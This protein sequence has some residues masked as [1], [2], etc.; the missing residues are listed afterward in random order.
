[1]TEDGRQ[2]KPGLRSWNDAIE[3][4]L[5]LAKELE[6]QHELLE[7]DEFGVAVLLP[8]QEKLPI[9]MRLVWQGDLAG[10]QSDI[11]Q[12]EF[13][14]DPDDGGEESFANIADVLAGIVAKRIRLRCYYRADASLPYKVKL[15]SRDDGGRWERIFTYSY[16]WPW[17]R[18]AQIR[19]MN[20]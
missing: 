9:Q 4:F 12:M 16:G 15:E 3:A 13:W 11:F 2:N 14:V 7:S 1:M 20:T 8:H 6:L 17:S 10:I 5:A 19:L 18:R